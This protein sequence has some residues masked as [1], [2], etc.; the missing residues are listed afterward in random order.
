MPIPAGAETTQSGYEFY[1]QGLEHVLRRAAEDFKKPLYIPE[2]GIATADDARRLAFIEATLECVQ[3][4]ITDGLPVKGYFHRSLMDN[5][6][7][8][9]GC[10]MTFCLIVVDRQGGQART[11]SPVWLTRVL[12]GAPICHTTGVWQ[13]FCVDMSKA[14]ITRRPRSVL[15][16]LSDRTKAVP[17]QGS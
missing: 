7:W 5:F 12:G 6:E 11:P 8:K 9:K 15:R 2:N 16:L 13:Y 1:P 17:G 10:A 3:R 4:C 14:G